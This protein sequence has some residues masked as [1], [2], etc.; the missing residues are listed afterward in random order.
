MGT[1]CSGL[2]SIRALVTCPKRTSTNALLSA[3]FPSATTRTV[4]GPGVRPS[5]GLING[6]APICFPSTNSIAPAT[7]GTSMR[8]A[9]TKRAGASSCTTASRSVS[10]SASGEPDTGCVARR[11]SA[12]E[13]ASS[14]FRSIMNASPSWLAVPMISSRAPARDAAKAAQA[15]LASQSGS[16]L[17]CSARSFSGASLASG[18]AESSLRSVTWSACTSS[19]GTPS[20]CSGISATTGRASWATGAL[21]AARTSAR[22]P[23][24]PA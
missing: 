5:M 8:M 6:V 19:G 16:R 17:S 24:A 15:I 14:S 18:S 1:A 23:S 13:R 22:W 10:I 9:P 7:P 21:P 3:A 2:S 12:A 4:C 20:G 11:S